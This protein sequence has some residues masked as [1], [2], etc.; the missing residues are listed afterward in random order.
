MCLD[1]EVILWQSRPTGN[2]LIKLVLLNVAVTGKL[3]DP[4]LHDGL[5]G[6][7]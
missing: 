1:E 2:I 5:L 3:F 4:N 7:A 6:F